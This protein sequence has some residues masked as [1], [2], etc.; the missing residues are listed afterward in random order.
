MQWGVARWGGVIASAGVSTPPAGPFA[1][2]ALIRLSAI[3]SAAGLAF[4]FSD[5]RTPNV[6]QLLAAPHL[7]VAL[8]VS[9]R[10]RESVIATLVLSIASLVLLTLLTMLFVLAGGWDTTGRTYHSTRVLFGVL[11]LQ[12]GLVCLSVAALPYAPAGPGGA[13]SPVTPS[14]VTPSP[15]TPDP[16]PVRSF[17]L[18]LEGWIEENPDEG[19]RFW[20]DAA[21]DVMSLAAADPSAGGLLDPTS[22][23]EL[24]RSARRLAESAGGGLIEVSRAAHGSLPLVRLVYKRLQHPAY[25]YTGM[26]FMAGQATTLVF[27]IV[28]GEGNMTGIREATVTAE[29]MQSGELTPESYPHVWAQDPYDATYHGVDRSVLRFLSDRGRYDRRFPQHPLS[30]VRRVLAALSGSVAGPR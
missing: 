29:L 15:V 6:L 2:M 20:R 27:T 8:S 1:L 13:P 25:V 5:N 26:L 14:P 7:L 18:S 10:K 16:D 11:F 24:Q 23:A 9:E 3:L 30:K 22:D 12:F 21:G 17:H 28:A 4:V 19:M